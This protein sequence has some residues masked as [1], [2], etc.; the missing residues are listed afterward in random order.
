MH[1]NI[2]NGWLGGVLS[3]TNKISEPRELTALVQDLI[4]EFKEH[5]S[6]MKSTLDELV[7]K[8]DGLTVW[9]SANEAAIKEHN[10]KVHTN[11]DDIKTN[12]Y[13]ISE[14][15]HTIK[16]LEKDKEQSLQNGLMNR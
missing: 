7:E 15:K 11:I 2:Q 4:A 3:S 8:I 1:E 13:K 5:R 16:Q 12:R 6:T 9:V 10:T 14:L